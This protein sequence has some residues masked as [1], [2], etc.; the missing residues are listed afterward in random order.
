MLEH[1]VGVESDKVAAETRVADAES[2]ERSAKRLTS[3]LGASSGDSIVKSP[4]DGVVLS[5]HATPGA[6]VGQESDA[7][8]EIGDPA[9]LWVVADLFEGDVGLVTSGASASVELANSPAPIAGRVVS[10]GRALDPNLRR[11]PTYIELTSDASTLRSGMYAR[12][13]IDSKDQRAIPVPSSAVLIKDQD[14]YIVFVT[15]DGMSFVPREVRI[16]K[17]SGGRVPVFSGLEPGE[18]IVTRGAILLDGAASR[19]L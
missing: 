3:V 11:C 6:S 5:L 12:V 1:G 17:P 16:G 15:T 7:L 13:T 10:V 9:A 18:R 14:R 19:L 8:V 2:R 4:I